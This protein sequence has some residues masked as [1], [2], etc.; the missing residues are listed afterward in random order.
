MSASEDEQLPS[1]EVE[2]A[3][4]ATQD[5]G[6]GFIARF[7]SAILLVGILLAIILF[8]A[9]AT[10]SNSGNRGLYPALPSPTSRPQLIDT[11]AATQLTFT[12]L[13]SDPTAYRD[14][15]I[16][17]SG[18]YTPLAL[19]DCRP[20]SGVPIR[21]SLVSEGLQLNAR[22][23]ES[24]LRLVD[25]GTKLTLTGYW[26]L[27]QG[28]V[29][30]GKAPPRGVV[31]Y[32]DVVQILEPNPLLAGASSL[33]LTVIPGSSLTTSLTVE[34]LTTPTLTATPFETPTIEIEATESNLPIQPPGL[35]ATPTETPTFAIP[36][37]VTSTPDPNATP[38][39]DVPP[40]ADATPG[41]T[42]TIPG[43]DDG[44]PIPGLPTN[45]PPSSG[46]PPDP[47]NTP[48]GG[49]P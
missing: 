10:F 45:T 49:Y 43:T 31:W 40:D 8:L 5:S 29:G 36:P 48:T 16:Q 47:T 7:G 22:G 42:P 34:A 38:T 37:T 24:I 13:N 18:D 4:A 9:V 6:A 33:A 46:Y 15:L 2:L 23:F 32:L 27:Y 12:Q 1:D 30:C 3:T 11:Q 14:E 39:S 19:P 44:T 20:W 41:S 25:P 35:P 28:P 21:W 17:V 26:R